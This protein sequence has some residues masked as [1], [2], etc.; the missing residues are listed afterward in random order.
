MTARHIALKINRPLQ[1][2]NSYPKPR[3]VHCSS[4][5]LEH[6]SSPRETGI[7]STLSHRTEH[8]VLT[9]FFSPFRL[10]PYFL[11]F[12]VVLPRLDVSFRGRCVLSRPAK[13]RPCGSIV[14]LFLPLSICI[15]RRF[16]LPPA[17]FTGSARRLHSTFFLLMH[18]LARYCCRTPKTTFL[19]DTTMYDV[20]KR[21]NMRQKA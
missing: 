13:I 11:M 19:D 2:H 9:A 10:L 15:R 1:P 17:A 3:V 7:H 8:D 16:V 6:S 4:F 21:E 14:S 18:T 5:I 20:T 12:A